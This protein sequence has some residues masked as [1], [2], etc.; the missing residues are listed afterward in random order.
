MPELPDVET[1]RRQFDLRMPGRSIYAV[2]ISDPRILHD[3]EPRYFKTT[4][5]GKLFGAADRRGKYL[6]AA[7]QPGFW[8]V[9]HFGMGG[10]FQY[11]KQSEEPSE[12]ARIV[13]TLDK[14]EK[15]GYIN[16]RL[17]GGVWLITDVGEF[18]VEKH[19][20]PDAMDV[21]FDEAAVKRAFAGKHAPIKMLLMDQSLVAG[22]G[23]IYADEILYQ[24]RLNPRTPAEKI[25]DG[26]WKDIAAKIKWVMEKAIENGADP[27]RFP[28]D[29]LLPHRQ[30]GEPCPCGGSVDNF[31][32]GGR[33]TY[34][35]PACQKQA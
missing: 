32:L 29:M 2:D 1:I 11:L 22:I 15:L 27:A 33:G 20:G 3:V 7:T 14:E 16:I 30:K 6:F 25:D 13:F 31:I 12:Y 17:F 34:Y 5:K 21:D 9:F 28:G 35:C 24:A 26:K 4:L 19:L 18:I 8:I 10:S 23:N